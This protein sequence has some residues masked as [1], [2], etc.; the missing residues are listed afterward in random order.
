[1]LISNPTD[2]HAALSFL[3]ECIGSAVIDCGCPHTCCG[4][5]WLKI[6]EDSL[7]ANQ[8]KLIEV[9]ECSKKYRFGDGNEVT[10]TK[11]VKLPVFFGK[12]K[13]FLTVD[14]VP[15]LIPLLLSTSSLT[16]GKADISFENKVMVLLDEKLPLQETKS[17]HLLVSIS[18]PTDANQP[19]VKRILL[20][21]SCNGK[22]KSNLKT[23][24]KLHKQFAHPP[25][26]RLNSLLKDSG[27]TDKELFECVEKVSSECETCQQLQRPPDRPV[28]GFPLASEFNEVVAMD[29]KQLEPGV[30]VLH[31]IDHATRYSSGCIIHNKR[32]ETIVE[33]ILLYW[34][35]WFGPPKKYLC[36]NGGEFVN[37]EVIDLA[38][39]CNVTIKTTAA[40]SPWSNGLCER[41]NAVIGSSIQKVRLDT[42]C[43]LSVALAWSISAKNCLCN[44][45]G[46]SPNQLVFGKNPN[47]PS[48]LDNKIPA[49]NGIC[50]SKMLESHL[51]ALHSARQRFI[52][53]EAAEK[54]KRALARKTR[55]YSDKVYCIGDMVY[56]KRLASE[57]WHG[58]AR[59]LGRD[60]QICLLKHGGFYI[61]VHPC[62]M[63]PVQ[64]A[65][66][67]TC[68]IEPSAS[69]SAPSNP[70]VGT[71]GTDTDSDASDDE[72]SS[73]GTD[74]NE[75]LPLSNPSE[76]TTPVDESVPA[77][78]GPASCAKDMPK[79]REVIAYKTSEDD[80][81]RF[82]KVLSRGGKVGG[83]HWHFL[84]IQPV[85]SVDPA[86]V[87]AV[88]FRD[89][90][91]QWRTALDTEVIDH[92]VVQGVQSSVSQFVY[93]GNQVDSDKF[94]HAKADE[95]NKWQSMKVYSEVENTGQT[96]ISTRWVCTEKVKGGSVVYKARLVARGFEE[97][98]S[99]LTK[100]SP[101]CSKDS[102]RLAL[103][104]I[105]TNQWKLCTIDIKSA[106][107]QGIPLSRDVFLKPPKEAK[108]DKLWKLNQAVYG[109]S[110]A[111]RHWY[112][113]VKDELLKLHVNM[114]KLDKSVFYYCK[115][116]TCEG[117]LIVH[118]DDFLFGGTDVFMNDV[119]SKLY[120]LF[121]VGVSESSSMKYLGIDVKQTDLGIHMS[122][123]EYIETIIPVAIDS[124]R[125]DEKHMAL[126]LSEVDEFR[127]LTGQINWC[128]TQ[129]RLDVCF[130][131]CQLSNAS[132][133][134]V[135]HLLIANKSVKNLKS[136]S[137]SIRL[138]PLQGDDLS[139]C[140]FSDA[141]FGNLP[142]GG[143]QGAYVAFIV[144]KL[145]NANILSW[146]SRKVRRVCNSTLSAECL[147]AV[148]AVKAGVLLKHLVSEL[149]CWTN[150]DMNIITDNKSL[151]QAINSV[152][153]VDDKR[154][155]IEI[156]MLQ[157]SMERKE[158]ENIYM[159][160][161][162]HN[163]ANALTKQGAS[164]VVL[165]NVLSGKM[166][167]NHDLHY[168]EQV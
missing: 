12:V 16:A 159:V 130:T 11:T 19:H 39:K 135:N 32:K 139:I 68:N 82:G 74:V 18:R 107:L 71:S 158:F 69:T 160:P 66:N 154:L 7:S 36:D 101:T 127:H 46:F 142:S 78:K 4:D 2:D 57:N 34:V 120:N 51:N 124:F 22:G 53:A 152:T 133:P 6:Y 31:L 122:M 83:L 103:S 118:V 91:L 104:I 37:D 114:S 41:H 164:C 27:I 116:G 121:V 111:G 89:D 153:P 149:K 70:D 8:K 112:D 43:S 129:V 29:L 54:V 80:S 14:V 151:V 138:S 49:N 60:G 144:D 35:K 76:V 62:R 47:F 15:A 50:T 145:G 137:L 98:S 38:E 9:S 55:T 117:V 94:E 85:G 64:E 24:L 131:N 75:P 150:I 167:Y 92:P 67:S 147:A 77:L 136:T 48:V 109:L 45:Y 81:W 95:L 168:F 166:R 157:E 143:S 30:Y 128:A 126:S 58:P 84:N 100:K 140:V 87:D 156:A 97:D 59:L 21:S 165:N 3:S 33:G 40:E 63:A 148:D 26:Y 134:T 56:Y 86:S 28:V 161:S 73:T 163:L 102:F 115:N 61:R 113:R 52:E 105:T 123:D 20:N 5:L 90:V 17:G 125:R 132:K 96:S 13:A 72:S 79:I 42:G 141:S 108:S 93:I 1:M 162:K 119:V 155:R 146:Q 99:H 106:F 44:V 110:D 88:S 25:P 10:A 23:A 65:E